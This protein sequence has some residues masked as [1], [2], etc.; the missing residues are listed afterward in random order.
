M[1]TESNTPRD[2]EQIAEL[3]CL[4]APDQVAEADL[5]RCF[6]DIYSFWSLCDVAACRRGG[7]C[8]GDAA[9]CCDLCMPF[10]SDEV[11]EG[12]QCLVEAKLDKLSFEEAMKRWPDEL[13]I[14][15]AWKTRIE[16]RVGASRPRGRVSRGRSRA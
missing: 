8:S 4:D 1:T 5:K 3:E 11:F 15:W 7:R 13:G 9:R 14:L 10:I 6:S 12:G 16:N 2:R